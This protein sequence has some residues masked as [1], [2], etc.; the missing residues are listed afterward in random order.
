LL[1]ARKISCRILHEKKNAYY[2][3]WN[4]TIWRFIL[5][6]V[7]SKN[8]LKCNTYNIDRR[9]DTDKKD[10]QENK[11]SF[12]VMYC[13]E[14]EVAW[15]FRDGRSYGRDFP[16]KRKLKHKVCMSCRNVVIFNGIYNKFL[17]LKEIHYTQL[18]GDVYKQYLKLK[19]GVR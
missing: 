10:L 12:L 9:S 5:V 18:L 15:E 1:P 19:K 11:E 3:I 17:E 7:M 2:I 13:P 6:T 8:Y 14:C 16:M 4:N